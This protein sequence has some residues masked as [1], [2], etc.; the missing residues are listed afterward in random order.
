MWRGSAKATSWRSK[1]VSDDPQKAA[2]LA[3]LIANDYVADQV[4][5]RVKVI[6]QAAGLFADRLDALRAQVRASE[7]ALA[8]YRQRNG[9]MTTSDEKITISDQQLGNLNER[10]AFASVR[11]AALRLAKYDQAARFERGAGDPNTLPEV[12][13]SP[14]VIQLRNQLTECQ[15][16]EADA[17]RWSTATLYPRHRSIEG[18][19]EGAAV[20]VS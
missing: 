1:F 17:R 15:R 13:Q 7:N 2:R 3:N 19:E 9:M 4:A 8:G 11:T 20:G 5:A 10:L 6:Q 12:V 18:A 14:A 16:Q